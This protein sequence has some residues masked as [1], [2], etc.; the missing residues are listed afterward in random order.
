MTR[1]G[2]TI[3]EL[4]VTVTIIAILITA[5]AA[6]IVRARRVGRDSQRIRDVLA[7]G[8]AIDQ[9]A[10]NARGSYPYD[11]ASQNT[12]VM[13]L[14]QLGTSTNNKN[15]INFGLFFNRSMP[16][17]P[18]PELDSATCTNYRDGYTY[19]NRYGAAVNLARPASGQ[20]YEYV[21]EVGLE[22]DRPADEQTLTAGSDSSSTVRKQFLLLGKPC[23]PLFNGTCSLP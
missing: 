4:M 16:K 17:D 12:N 9:A 2:F 23:T 3:I 7:V 5:A 10:T 13:C 22:G 19:S 6:G 11:V 20:N 21:L 8:V 14:D 18:A 15:G 1:R